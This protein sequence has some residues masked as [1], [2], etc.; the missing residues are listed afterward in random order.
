MQALFEI[1][2]CFWLHKNQDTN[3]ARST[4]DIMIL[5]KELQNH[6]GKLFLCP[7]QKQVKT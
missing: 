5:F 6:I 2:N 4:K 7:P 1:G 3:F